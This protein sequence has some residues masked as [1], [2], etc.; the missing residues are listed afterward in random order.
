[1]RRRLVDVC[2]GFAPPADLAGHFDYRLQVLRK[3]VSSHGDA[4]RYYITFLDNHDLNERFHNAQY[5]EQTRLALACLMTLQGIPCIYYGTEQG[6]DGR[7]DRREYAREALW[8]R[9]GAFRSDHEIYRH[10]RNLTRLRAE[11]PVVRFGRSPY[12]GG[13]LAFSR[14]LNDRE[15]LL[16]ANASSVQPVQIHVVVDRN[17]HA[18]GKAWTVLFSTHAQPQA[19]MPTSTH[20]DL[21]TLQLNLAPMEVQ[22]LG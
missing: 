12:R 18:A 1:M 3:I 14:I 13:V 8:G 10:I 17:L 22:V 2:K 11:N 9:P 6:L 21:R 4:G 20:G 15:V 16:A 5:P 7:G 19:P